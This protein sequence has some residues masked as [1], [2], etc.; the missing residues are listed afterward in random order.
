MLGQGLLLLPSAACELSDLGVDIGPQQ[1]WI[2]PS[3][4]NAGPV[5]CSVGS[6][7]L[8]GERQTWF[9]CVLVGSGLLLLSPTSPA[10][11]FLPSQN[12]RIF[13]GITRRFWV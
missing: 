8:D 9:L 11:P 3:S 2:T 13:F 12:L 5:A 1:H 10:A 6:N 4:E 7:C